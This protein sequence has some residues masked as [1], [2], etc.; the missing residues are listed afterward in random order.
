MKGSGLK[1]GDDR[2]LWQ[3]VLHAIRLFPLTAS[4]SK[5]LIGVS[6]GADSL[7]LL[8]LLWRKLGPDRLVVA[9]LDHQLRPE[10]KLDADF[11]AETAVSWGIDFVTKRVDVVSMAKKERLSLEAAGRLARYQFF[12]RKVKEL[13]LAAVAVGHHGDD[14]A[15]TVLLHLLRGSGGVRGMQAVGSVP[16]TD[17]VV[18]LRPFLNTPRSQIEA[19][20]ERHQLTPR[21]DPSNNDETFTR[22]RI[23]HE[24]L[25]MLQTYNPQIQQNLRQLAIIS[26]DEQAALQQQF[27]QIWPTLLVEQT[28]NARQLDR[29]RFQDLD[30]AWQ[31][32]AL[33]RVVQLLRPKVTDV[34]FQTI[35]MARHLIL[36]DRSGTEAWLPGGLI[37]QVTG[38]AVTFGDAN[39]ADF[40]SM[41]QLLDEQEVSLP[42]LGHF[43]LANGWLISAKVVQNVSLA[44]VSQNE[45][46]WQAYVALAENQSLRIRPSQPNERFQP[47][48]LDGH[49][50]EIADLLSNRKVPRGRR[51]LW[52]VVITDAHPVWIVG[53]HLDNR[54]RVTKKSP[55]IVKLSCYRR[56]G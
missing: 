30:V 41:P 47:L 12:A 13:D 17:D 15:E 11:V 26:A 54:A 24:L 36:E 23:R 3:A 2:K 42:I 52:P 34:S 22:N 1:F 48:G 35:E 6:G 51:L 49:T 40:A 50:Q 29:R 20:C 32:F 55:R 7:A 5:L 16:G 45:N 21:I 25:P 43:E 4:H 18:L 10:S 56:E 33:R 38:Q 44:E 28:N 46:E 27:D 53:L 31:R 37:M 14:Q 9:H 39:E 19:Y 8:H